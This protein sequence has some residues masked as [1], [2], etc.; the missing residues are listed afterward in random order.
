VNYFI[1]TVSLLSRACGVAAA[2]MLALAVF[3]VCHMVWVR[4]VLEASSSWQTEFVTYLLIA[5][6]F[7]GS[8]YVLLLR[9]HVNVDLL[10]IYLGKRGRFALALFAYLSS[11][12][13]CV[14]IAWLGYELWYESWDNGWLSD[15]V[16]EVRLWIPYVA[17]PLGFGI[18]S[19]QY[20]ADIACLLTGRE[21][22]FGMAEEGE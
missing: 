1:K 13:F 4:D 8:P 16:W 20:V 2:L 6:T 7:V 9:G 19:L 15:T 21:A 18:M 5:A 3:V 11:L 12:V 22:P 14:I 17:M 10:P